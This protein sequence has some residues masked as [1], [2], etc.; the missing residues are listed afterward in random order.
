[1]EAY[2]LLESL[3]SLNISRSLEESNCVLDL[4]KYLF[5]CRVDLKTGVI[6]LKQS[7]SFALSV[8]H[9]YMLLLM[10]FIFFVLSCRSK[11]TI[12]R[13]NIENINSLEIQLWSCCIMFLKCSCF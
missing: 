1:M 10:V 6:P 3:I 7:L 9:A 12:V 5:T 4:C 8:V 13:L 11:A 2:L